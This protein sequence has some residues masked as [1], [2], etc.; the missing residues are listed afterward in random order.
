MILNFHHVTYHKKI[1]QR[2]LW[3]AGRSLGIAIMIG[4]LG[5][6]SACAQTRGHAGSG[7]APVSNSAS[8]VN[9]LLGTGSGGK[10]TG[11]VDTF[12]GAVVPFGMLSWSPTTPT[13]PE[14]GDYFYKDSKISGFSLTHVSGPGCSSGGE[15]P[16]LP[17]VGQVG[18]HPGKSTEPF[19]HKHEHASPGV[20]QVTLAPGGSAPI[21]VKLSATTRSG[22]GTFHFPATGQAN[23]LFKVS[24]AQQKTSTNEVH[25][26]GHNKVVGLDTSGH[27]CGTASSETTYFVAEFNRP[28]KTHGA[29]SAGHTSSKDGAAGAGTGAWVSFDTRTHR[30]IKLKV[31]ISYVSTAD[32]WANLKAEDAGWS[33][34]EIAKKAHQA[35]NQVLSRI[36]VAGGSNSQKIQFYTA[37]Y[38]SLL[39]PNVFSDASGT[40]IGFDDKV[41]HLAKGQ[42]AQY[43]NF[44]GWDIYRSEV[45]LQALLL[46]ERVS[47]MMQSLLNDQA[48][49]GWLPKWGYDNDYSGVMNGDAADPII[50][51]AYTFGARHFD[52]K[53]AL[54]AMIKGA[55][56]TPADY[57]RGQSWYQERP[58]LKAYMKHGYVPKDASETLEYA[59]ADFGIARMAKALGQ[60]SVYQR[61]LTRSQNWSNI[62]DSHASFRGHS[63]YIEPRTAKGAFPVGPAF[64]I[65]SKAYGQAGFEEGNTIQY[66]WMIPQNLHGLIHAMGGNQDALKR[67]DEMF[68]QLN[69]G[70]N[71]PYYWAGNEPDL[72]FPWIYDYAGAPCKT[73]QIVHRLIRKVY[74]NSPGGEPGNDDLG[75][76][77]SW[78]VW[79]DMGMF[80]ETPGTAVLTLGAPIFSHVTLHLP[81]GRTLNLAAPQASTHAY[82]KSLKVN[83]KAWHKDWLSADMFLGT[84]APSSS[85]NSSHSTTLNFQMSKQPN[86][87]WATSEDDE[88]PSYPARGEL[89]T[90]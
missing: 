62:F 30:T 49:G 18:T 28:F 41:H 59:L 12:P 3:I 27:F 53:A 77:S 38:H 54:K 32:A 83:G 9:P 47:D 2:S 45:P 71:K 10:V 66:T 23:F 29:W 78:L 46:P 56:K 5:I 13:R 58:D 15:V 65:K 63:G 42:K 16:I 4:S 68:T 14:G 74:S 37:L 73:Q 8:L 75:A 6:G 61:F 26:I 57:R 72:N 82:V 70:P 20:Y 51:E 43:A 55:T 64:Q 84:S 60:A 17:T 48:Q 76:T 35:W 69:V 19:S 86:K 34:P 67:L 7:G 11:D 52:T 87:T 1:C 44:S 90:P 89:N 81:H 36:S 22:I 33:L 80:P 85:G 25:V 21:A 50:A 40:Y 24:D 31:A 88:P 79:A 39:H